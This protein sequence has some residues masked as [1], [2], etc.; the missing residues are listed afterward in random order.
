MRKLNREKEDR[1]THKVKVKQLLKFKV[2][3][4][5][6][7]NIILRK[8]MSGHWVSYYIRCFMAK[9]LMM[10]NLFKI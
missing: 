5:Y 1:V 7:V 8:A 9:S 3:L 2:I 4:Q 10:E 6:R